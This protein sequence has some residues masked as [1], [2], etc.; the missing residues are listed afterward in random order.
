MYMVIFNVP[1]SHVDVV[2]EA[3]FAAGAGYY[4]NYSHCSWQCLGEGQFM[5]LEGSRPF[6]GTA[7]QLETVPEYRVE[8]ICGDD[9]IQEVV[10][11]LRQ[12]HP[13]EEPSIQVLRMED[14]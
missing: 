14:F 8:T 2:K 9:C 1:V 4:G 13:Y 7:H 5:P 11:A 6:V 12:A 10:V 3:I